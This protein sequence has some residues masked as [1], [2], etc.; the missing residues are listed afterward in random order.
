MTKKKEKSKRKREKV[1]MFI[2]QIYMYFAFVYRISNG[3]R[4]PGKAL[5]ERDA[6]SRISVIIK[7]M[8][9]QRAFCFEFHAALLLTCGQSVLLRS[10]Y[11]ASNLK[12]YPRMFKQSNSFNS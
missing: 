9:R 4:Y 2:I 8:M 1:E 5:H 3:K 11:V 10:R 12:S 6:V 7:K